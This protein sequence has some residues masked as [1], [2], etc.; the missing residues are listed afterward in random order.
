MAL[1][2]A[3]VGAALVVGVASVRP[4]RAEQ[5]VVR[6]ALV[7]PGVVQVGQAVRFAGLDL[8]CVY[9]WYLGGRQVFCGRITT[10][11]G[12]A[13]VV[14]RHR[15]QVLQFGGTQQQRAVLFTAL[16]VP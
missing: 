15:V 13:V 9:K 2:A 3:L 1:A 8:R 12:V 7:R 11:A 4:A 10:A 14:H 6:Q 16:R 5:R